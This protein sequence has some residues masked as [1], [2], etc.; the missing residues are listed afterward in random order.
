MKRV[1]LNVQEKF[2]EFLDK[3]VELGL[4]PS[5]NEIIR[6]AIK[7]WIQKESIFLSNFNSDTKKLSELHRKFVEFNNSLKEQL[8]PI[9]SLKHRPSLPLQNLKSNKKVGD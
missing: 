7:D 5:R 2:I 3:E 4:Y 9:Y 6:I 8:F 1:N